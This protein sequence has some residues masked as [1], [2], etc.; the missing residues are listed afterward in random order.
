MMIMCRERSKISDE[1]RSAFKELT[2]RQHKLDLCK[3][4]VTNVDSQLSILFDNAPASAESEVHAEL[5]ARQKEGDA[6]RVCP[7]I[8]CL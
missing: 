8:L 3:K 2:A 4:L 5:L 1:M 6:L 7:C